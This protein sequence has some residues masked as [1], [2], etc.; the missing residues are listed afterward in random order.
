MPSE[1]KPQ[2]SWDCP[3][4]LLTRYSTQHAKSNELQKLHDELKAKQDRFKM[5][6]NE[7]WSDTREY[8]SNVFQKDS[9]VIQ[10]SCHLKFNE[11]SKK[12]EAYRPKACPMCES[13]RAT[14]GHRPLGLFMNFGESD[15][16]KGEGG[17][18]D[19][20]DDV[21]NDLFGSNKPNREQLDRLGN[22]S[23]EDENDD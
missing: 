9:D 5:D 15:K 2:A 16:P 3:D 18:A 23:A 19:N 14:P 13:E 4:H 8:L 20:T 6:C 7:L 1:H 17:M 11:K 12:I 10:G 21:I 22:Q